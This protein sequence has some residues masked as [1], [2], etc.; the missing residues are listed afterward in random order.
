MYQVRLF[1]KYDYSKVKYHN[2]KTKIEIICP[3]HGS[4][5]QDPTHHL[6]GKNGKG[7]SKCAGNLKYDTISFIKKVKEVHGDLYDYSLVEYKNIKTKIIIICKK[8]GKFM[9]TPHH[10][11]SGKGCSSCKTSSKG[12]LIIQDYLNKHNIE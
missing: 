3:V 7:C 6:E 10:H 2:R 11:L 1:V 9:Q 8:H 5:F 12:E 4:F